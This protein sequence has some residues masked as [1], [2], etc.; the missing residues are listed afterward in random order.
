MLFYKSSLSCSEAA[1]VGELWDNE[2][3]IYRYSDT[4]LE[5]S[6]TLILHADGIRS[7]R[8]LLLRLLVR[9]ATLP[10][11]RSASGALLVISMR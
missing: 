5:L 9:T 2:F 4:Q 11:C 3:A 6:A 7:L 1:D 10:R 8:V